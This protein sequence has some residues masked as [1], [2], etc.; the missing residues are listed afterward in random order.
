VCCGQDQIARHRRSRVQPDVVARRR[1]PA[2]CGWP[3]QARQALAA[4][5]IAVQAP[6]LSAYDEL[7][8]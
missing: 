7:V 5:D 6:S 2:S 3:R 4:D 1:A 8:G